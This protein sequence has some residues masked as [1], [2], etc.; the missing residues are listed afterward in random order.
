VRNRARGMNASRPLRRC[1][2]GLARFKENLSL[3]SNQAC[4]KSHLL[5]AIDLMLGSTLALQE[6]TN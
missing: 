3:S 6:A 1:S 5:G 4:T 2:S